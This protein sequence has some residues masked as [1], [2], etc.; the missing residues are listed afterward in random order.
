VRD[1]KR[2]RTALRLSQSAL[3]R[4]AGV[5]RVHLVLAELGDRPLNAQ[6]ED[7]IQRALLWETERLRN[8]DVTLPLMH[9]EVYDQ[10]QTQESS[11]GP[12]RLS[13]RKSL[14][15]GTKA[16][17]LSAKTERDRANRR[18]RTVGEAR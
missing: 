5:P 4:M 7:K 11:G 9:D 3:A 18:R 6:E 10:T 14:G 16:A 2:A 15:Q 17:N 8:V 12:A 13:R 1:L